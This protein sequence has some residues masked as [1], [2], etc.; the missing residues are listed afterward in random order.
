LEYQDSVLELVLYLLYT[1]DLPV[2]P[3]TITATYAYDTAILMAHKDHIEALT[4]KPIPYSNMAKKM[5]NQSQWGKICTSDFH[6]PQKDVPTSNL[7]RREYPLSREHGVFE[8]TSRSQ[9]KLEK[10]H[11]HQENLE[12]N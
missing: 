3:D 2:A 8:T 6:H 4:K 9:T 12:F 7:E 11:I 5:E 10:T 1:V